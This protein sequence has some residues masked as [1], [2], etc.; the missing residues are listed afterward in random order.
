MTHGQE[1]RANLDLVRAMYEAVLMPMNA[2]AVD[3]YFRADYIQHS[4]LAADGREALKSF[5]RGA[6]Q[7]NPD[8]A[9]ILKRIFADGDRVICHVHV[10]LKP[11]TPGLAVVDIFRVQDGLIAEHWDVAQPVV[12]DGPNK[13][14]MF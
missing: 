10:V 8:C 2:E 1:E 3:A 11:D 9:H 4:P 6:K 13:N 5:L 7:R 12:V 14:G